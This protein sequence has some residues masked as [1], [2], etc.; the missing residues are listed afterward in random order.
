MKIGII[1]AGHIGGNLARL[2]ARAGHDVMISFSRDPA[3][4]VAFAQ[5]IDVLVGSPYEAADFGEVVVLAVPWAAINEALT[6]AQGPES[7]A[8]KVVVDTTNQF[9]R[10]NGNIGVV[11]LG[12]VSG[13]RHNASKVPAARWAKA[14]NTLTAQFQADSAG[15]TGDDRVVMFYAADDDTAADV[16]AQI[17]SDIGFDPVRTG[18]LNRNEVGHQEPNGELYGK[19]FHHDDAVAAVTKLRGKHPGDS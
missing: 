9:G 5:E 19:E 3:T 15:R 16:V 14:F 13:A 2:F 10:V 11:D 7:L 6:E 1:G 4:L 18:T 17:V 8:G 12:D